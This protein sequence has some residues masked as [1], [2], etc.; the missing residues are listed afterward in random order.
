[1]ASPTDPSRA[2]TFQLLGP[3]RAWRGGRQLALGSPQQRAT[4]AVLLLS[5]GRPVSVSELVDALWGEEPPPRAVGTLR[6]YVSRLRAL[7]EPDRQARGRASLLVSAG[8]GYALR[9]PRGALDATGLEDRLTAARRLRGARQ[10]AG[11]YG[12][13]TAA[14]ALS[15]GTPLAGLPGPYAERQRDRLTEL[16]VTAQEE[17]FA[18][19]LELGRYAEATPPLRAFA[20]EHPLRERAQALLMLALRRGGR[21]ADALAVYEATR[22]TLATELG[23]DPG[24]ELATLHEDL[25]KGDAFPAPTASGQNTGTARQAPAQRV[26]AQRAASSVRRLSEAARERGGARAPDDADGNAQARTRDRR[27]AAGVAVRRPMCTE[28][29]EPTTAPDGGASLAV[30]PERAAARPRTPARP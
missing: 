29:P 23:V 13:L 1:P 15:N 26:G 17:L 28:A 25:L 4:L 24:A 10:H 3:V 20:A 18:C 5:H 14:L 7:L 30:A 2:L 27:P 8:G 11:A 22:H 16:S 19:A 12:E 9:V 21:Q 6:T